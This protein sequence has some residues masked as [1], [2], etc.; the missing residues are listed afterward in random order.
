MKHIL[1][2]LFV[3][4]SL[5]LNGCGTGSPRFVNTDKSKTGSEG[6]DDSSVRFARAL[7]RASLEE[8]NEDDVKV[9]IAAVE[10]RLREGELPAPATGT[11]KIVL[12]TPQ[13][14]VLLQEVLKHIGTP[15]RL[16]GSGRDGIDCSAYTA[17][18]FRNALNIDLPRSTSDQ[19]RIGTTVREH[20]LQFGDLIFFNTTG[21]NPSHVGIYIGDGLFAHASVSYGVTISS[22]QSR[23]FQRRMTGIRR[24]IY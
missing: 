2:P 10:N 18:V 3:S 4:L 17:V 23:Y 21:T 6:S 16:G 12:P 5:I 20:E 22:L 24:V 11:S 14:T 15:Y 1:F 19:Y 13:Q 8:K 9:D 7:E